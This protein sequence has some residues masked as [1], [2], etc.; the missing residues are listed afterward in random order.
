MEE[1]KNNKKLVKGIIFGLLLIIGILCFEFGEVDTDA[2][3]IEANWD[4]FVIHYNQDT[5]CMT[6][7]TNIIFTKLQIFGLVVLVAA[8]MNLFALLINKN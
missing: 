6:E 5:S 8:L 3:D 1:N 4:G 2:Y 7:Q